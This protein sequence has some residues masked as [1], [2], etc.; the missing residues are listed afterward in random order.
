MT[1]EIDAAFAKCKSKGRIAFVPYVT[2]GYPTKLDT[3]PQLLGLQK[4]GADI[5]ELG[6][7]FSDPLADGPTIQKSNFIALTNK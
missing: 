7:P 4:G 3:V 6:V 2:A 1:S 5:I